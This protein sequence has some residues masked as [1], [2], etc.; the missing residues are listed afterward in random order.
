MPLEIPTLDNRRYEDLLNEVLARI[1]VHTPEWT[2]YG[3]S[4]PGR[5]LLEL[6]CFLKESLLYQ[7]NQIPERN[8]RKFLQLLGIPLQPGGAAR[9][10]VVFAN[11]RGPLRTETL[12]ADLEVRAGKVPFQTERALDVL[13]IEGRVYYKRRVKTPAPRVEQYYRLLYAS[14]QGSAPPEGFKV[15]MYETVPLEQQEPHG[16]DLAADTV[17]GSLW[18]ALC[19]RAVDRPPQ[20]TEAGWSTL[21]DEVRKAI[22]G[23]TLSLGIVPALLDVSRRLSPAGDANKEGEPL[24][25]YELPK[26]P[27]GGVLP[28]DPK[29][30]V[31]EY[32]A[33][34][35]RAFTDVLI[36]P[37]VVEIALP[38]KDELGLWTN[39]DPLEAGVGEFPPALAD[40]NLDRRV[41]TWLRVRAV[42]GTHVRLL[43]VGINAVTVTQRAH[44]FSELLASGTGLPDQ[45]RVLAKKPVIAKSVRLSATVTHNGRTETW[46]EIDDLLLAGAEVDVPDPRLPPGRPR[47]PARRAD[48]FALDQEAGELRFGDGLRGKRPPEGAILRASYD[49]SMGAAGN[50]GKGMIDTGP[51]LPA[52]FTITN[53]IRTWGGADAESV[54]EGEKQIARYLV[55]RERLVTAEDFET[56]AMR[57]PGVDIGRLEVLPAFHPELSPN[58][59]GDAPGVVT[60]LVIPRNDPQQPDAPMPDRS[61]LNALCQHLDPRRLVTTELILCGPRY[62]PIWISVGINVK[63]GYALAEVRENVRK[64]LIEF[65][66]PIYPAKV[67]EPG[68]PGAKRE[69]GWPLRKDVDARELIAEASRVDGVLMVNGLRL[70]K[71]AEAPDSSVA[72]VALQLPRVMGIAVTAGEPQPIE[73]LRGQPTGVLGERGEPAALARVIPVPVVP[74]VC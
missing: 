66:A 21:R 73:S 2:N 50:V 18:V 70:A 3:P 4:D 47:E 29:L 34:D 19:A 38:A 17:D 14:Y 37:G 28:A 36:Y 67:E 33:R 12:N 23:K 44:V 46:Q 26:L 39:L 52:G 74:E 57:A 8:R 49:Y 11:E 10:I 27:P 16:I 22:E 69:K 60:L 25:R 13:P 53:P 48:V 64:R 6:F 65:L 43:W 56:V 51:A 35:P 71:G 24:L 68:A 63:A 7:A 54:A 58:E 61:F 45:K 20:D 9:G 1:P 30:H 41:V 72:M 5:T 42:G 32:K 31:A 59:P 15:D 40:T 55:H 62:V